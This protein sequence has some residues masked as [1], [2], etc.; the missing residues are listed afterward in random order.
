[1]EIRDEWL[2]HGLSTAPADRPA[3][4]TAVTSLY[5]R[6]GRARP[7]FAW[8]DSPAAA[9]PLVAGAPTHAVLHQWVM[10]PPSGPRPVASDLA[11][12]ASR[13]R[14]ALDERLEPPAFDPPPPKRTRKPP[15]PWPVLPAPDLLRRGIPFREV[16]TQ[17]VRDALRASL[18]LHPPVRAALGPPEAVPVCWYGQQDAH[19]IAYYDAW[20]RLG[21]ARYPRAD[22]AWLDTWAALA[23]ATGWWWPGDAVCVMVERPA[24]LRVEP[25]PGAWHGEVRPRRDGGPA[26]VWRDGWA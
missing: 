21:L 26:L 4:E 8:V 23:R 2:G 24:A 5:A 7:R 12:S 25:V 19:W 9:M 3:A 17:G 6:L 22:D 15:E 20:R 16:L 13:L 1:M 14:S 18:A 10:R 11:A